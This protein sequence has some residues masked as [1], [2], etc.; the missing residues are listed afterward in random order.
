MAPQAPSLPSSN[1]STIFYHILPSPR[2]SGPLK[3]G[4]RSES[5]LIIYLDD[6][7]LQVSRKYAKKYHEGGYTTIKAI[8]EDLEQ[9]V[10]I[11]WVSST[12]LSPSSEEAAVNQ[13]SFN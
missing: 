2:S 7:L 10:D 8:V 5:N 3:P 9:L 13:A 6:Q 12:R 4:S 11:L 1:N